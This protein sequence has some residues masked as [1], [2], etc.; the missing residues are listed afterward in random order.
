[1]GFFATF[2]SWLDAQLASYIGTN[3]ALVAR[4]LEPAIVTLGTVYVMVWGYLQL[5]GRI[6]EPLGTGLRRLVTL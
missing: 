3:T 2:W 6:E 5:T 4:A 1:M